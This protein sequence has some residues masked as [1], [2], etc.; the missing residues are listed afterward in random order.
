MCHEGSLTEDRA[1]SNR[2]RQSCGIILRSFSGG[3]SWRRDALIAQSLAQRCILLD[4]AI[5]LTLG[6]RQS[7]LRLRQLAAQLNEIFV[8]LGHGA[9]L[10]L[11]RHA[12]Y[13]INAEICVFVPHGL[14]LF[15]GWRTERGLR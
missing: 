14:R 2:V 5:A 3:F 10:M 1:L 12:L 8:P 11:L 13:G 9:P 4:R 7:G 15:V 6:T